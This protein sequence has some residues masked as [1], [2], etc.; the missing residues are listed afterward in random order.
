[1]FT[2]FATQNEAN[3]SDNGEQ[4]ANSQHGSVTISRKV[5]CED[6]VAQKKG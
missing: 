5:R 2:L 1:M 6:R 3:E 4:C